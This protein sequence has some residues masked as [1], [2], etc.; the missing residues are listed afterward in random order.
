MA[1]YWKSQPRKF[2][3]YCKCW[4][5][6]NKPSIE[7][8]ERGKNHKENVAAKISEIKKKS[9]DKA[10]QEAKM[11][12][13]FAAMEEAALKAYQE[14]LKRME[15]EAAGLS[16]PAP[17][18]AVATTQPS[19]QAK[20]QPKKQ[21]K[22]EKKSQMSTKQKE[23][24]VW[25]EGQSDD[26]NIY[27]Y[28]TVTGESQWEKPEGFQEQSSSFAQPA[29][30][31]SFSGC[32]WMEALSPDGFTYYYNT[33]T[34]ES[35]WEKPADFDSSREGQS[36]EEPLPPGAEEVKEEEAPASQ[37]APEEAPEQTSQQPNIPK[38]SFR[39]RKVEAEPSEKEE[40]EAKVSDEAPKTEAEEKPAEEEEVSTT[41]AEPEEKK[42]EA[43][44]EVKPA[45][46]PKAAAPYGVWEQI[47][48]EKDPYADVDLQ[49]PQVEG[50]STA[51]A[52]AE[53]PPEP[54]PKFK[55]RII[56]S[57]GEEGG[58]ASF[59]KNKTQNGKSRSLRQRD[60]DD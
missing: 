31:A 44:Q 2:C 47:R 16:S 40:E 39:K 17:A 33:E 25:V 34:G 26:G 22:K 20:P 28:N 12:K 52:P 3:Q 13:D 41:T 53:L 1:D 38:I 45:K 18:A 19:P 35:S 32:A 24:Q 29:Q 50:S 49:L 30:T 21:H 27:Y 55:E 37:E 54:K 4:I 10:K 15:R 6:D 56:T 59:R 7:F 58:P 51:S 60:N 57:L 5:A 43:V 9:I 14:D 48:E 46:R 8:H 36:Q 42:E 23:V 11:S